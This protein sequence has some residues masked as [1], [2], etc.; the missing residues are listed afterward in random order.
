[1]NKKILKNSFLG[2][3]VLLLLFLTFPQA[4]I[5]EEEVPP[6]PMTVQG[7]AQIDGTPAPRG[8]VVA[9]YL[10][11]EKVEEF[12]VNTSSGDYCFW[13]SGTGEDEGKP[14]T[15]TVDGKDAEKSLTWKS[16]DQVISLEL[17][18]GNVSN[19]S[20]K[21]DST[22][23]TGS[24]SLTGDETL[25][26]NSE[27]EVIENLIPEPNL[28]DQKN[29]SSKSGD[30]ETA[31]SAEDTSK[32]NSTPGFQIIYAVTGILLVFFGSNSGRE[33]RRKP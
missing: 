33:L 32:S 16:G 25:G 22:S 9:A 4:G 20:S 21:K 15:F 5:A 1:M 31:E 11:G 23:N 12:L 18:A 10:N 19:V 30:K 3:T 7:V 14:I 8:T 28:T 13:I 26:K 29:M 6:L 17:S 2:T 27:A 24:E